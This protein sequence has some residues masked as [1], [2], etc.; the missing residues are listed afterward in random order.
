MIGHLVKNVKNLQTY[1][2]RNILSHI[3]FITSS[4]GQQLNKH[5]ILC[6]Y[7]LFPRL[8]NVV[9]TDKNTSVNQ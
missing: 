3:S 8:C 7:L 5:L 9:L 4:T 1:C 2:R 6:A